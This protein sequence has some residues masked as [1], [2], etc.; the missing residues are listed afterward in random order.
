[1]IIVLTIALVGCFTMLGLAKVAGTEAMLARA[2]HVGLNS[3]AYKRI[4]ALELLAALG[5]LL[6]LVEPWIGLA[7]AVGLVLLMAGAFVTHLRNGDGPRE[8]APAAVMTA[9]LV[10]YLVLIPAG[11]G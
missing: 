10:G 4:G 8:I 11:T 5:L 6:G 1:M 2:A 7:A 9:V 3:T